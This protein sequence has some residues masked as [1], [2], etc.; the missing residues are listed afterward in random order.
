MS[1][2]GGAASMWDQLTTGGNAG[3]SE[4]VKDWTALCAAWARFHATVERD[5]FHNTTSPAG[6]IHTAAVPLGGASASAVQWPMMPPLPTPAPV[7]PKV[8]AV[9][10]KPDESKLAA[11][12]QYVLAS[13]QA[14]SGT[15]TA[16]ITQV[17]TLYMRG[18]IGANQ[19]NDQMARQYNFG[20]GAFQLLRVEASALKDLGKPEALRVLELFV[21][22]TQKAL[23]IVGG[24]VTQ[25][26]AFEMG[27]SKIWQKTM[28]EITATQLEINNDTR[29]AYDAANKNY[30]SKF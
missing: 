19:V 16:E 27:I 23:G 28:T 8:S 21:D 5:I 18:G 14:I 7:E 30:F 9:P 24:M 2:P 15:M 13:I 20:L 26:R 6:S 29:R 22:D 3:N 10:V 25:Q 4:V 1:G 17:S 12:E 11:R